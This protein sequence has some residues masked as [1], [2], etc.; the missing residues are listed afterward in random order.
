[1]DASENQVFLAVQHSDN[2]TVH[3]YISDAEGVNY[4]FSLDDVVTS[5]DWSVRRPSFDIHAVS[6]DHMGP[7]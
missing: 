3:L 2:A 4:A 6:V 1:M 7:L 5:D